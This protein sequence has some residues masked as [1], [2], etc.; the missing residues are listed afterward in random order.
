LNNL[1]EITNDLFD[2]AQRLKDVNEDY[3]LY[4]NVEKQH[5]EVHNR[6]QYPST[7]AFV[8]PYDELDARTI[9]Y[10]RFTS[11]NNST[12]LFEEIEKN[13]AMLDKQYQQQYVNS[14]MSQVE[15]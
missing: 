8:V 6:K 5:Y 11:V 12:K 2:I 1:I 4:F 14:V 3:V 7:L 9:K 13:N 15:G 10:A